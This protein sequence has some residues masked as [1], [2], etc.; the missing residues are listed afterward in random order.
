MA[1]LGTADF[2]VTQV[3]PATVELEGVSPLRWAREDVATP[4]EPFVGKVDAYDCTEEGPDGYM[5]L[6]L[7]FNTQEVVASLGSVNDGDVLVLSLM[8]SLLGGEGFVGEDVVVI[9]KKGK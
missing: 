8:G 2:D 3:D 1:I 4:Y 5:D 6:T 9:L 7:K